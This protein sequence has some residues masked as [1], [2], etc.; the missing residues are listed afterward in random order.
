MPFR[1]APLVLFAALA[2]FIAGDLF[3]VWPSLPERVA[4][5]FNA[6][7]D[8]NGWSTRSQLLF[9]LMAMFGTLPCYFM[10]QHGSSGYRTI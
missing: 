6:A 2:L 3:F 1:H 7:G 9:I 8:P 5:H 4:A 10:P